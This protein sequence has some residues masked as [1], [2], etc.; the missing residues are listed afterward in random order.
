MVHPCYHSFPPV[1]SVL[2][3]LAILP[4]LRIIL[5]EES[6]LLNAHINY[7]LDLVSAIFSHV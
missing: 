4:S 7:Q 1:A 5:D 2:P 6:Q 3:K